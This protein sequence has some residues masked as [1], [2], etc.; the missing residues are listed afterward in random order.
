MNEPLTFYPAHPSPSK[1]HQ[2]ETTPMPLLPQEA[3]FAV[4]PLCEAFRED[5]QG[6]LAIYLD[7]RFEVTG[8]ALKV[9]PDVHNKPSIELS[10][11]LGGETYALTIFP[12][13]EHYGKVSVGDR[14]TVRA[15]YLVLSNSF[16]V[17]MKFSELVSVEKAHA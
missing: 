11:R 17:V 2:I 15:N 14:V 10:D 6:A 16:G 7:K 12:T 1:T 5:L 4:K 3:P 9:G 8:I 13:E